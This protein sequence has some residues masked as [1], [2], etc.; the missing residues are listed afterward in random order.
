MTPAW[1]EGHPGSPRLFTERFATGDGRARFVDV[2]HRPPAEDVDEEF[3]V[4]L[5]TGRVLAQYQS[6]TQTRRVRSLRE[7]ASLVERARGRQL[8]V[9]L[10]HSVTRAQVQA[11]RE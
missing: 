1:L 5:T 8:N 4:L 2:D 3:P 10:C 6:G 11:A 9:W 7:A